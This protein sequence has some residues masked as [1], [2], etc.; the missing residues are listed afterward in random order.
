MTHDKLSSRP[1]ALGRE[2]GP[3]RSRAWAGRVRPSDPL[4]VAVWTL[5][6][7]TLAYLCA[8]AAGAVIRWW[9]W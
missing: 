6:V 1:T 4:V 8:H 9:A 7:L 5:V 2:E 3:G